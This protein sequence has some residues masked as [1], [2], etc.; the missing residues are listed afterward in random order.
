MKEKIVCDGFTG[1]DILIAYLCVHSFYVLETETLFDLREVITDAC[2]YGT[3]TF[4]N[5]N[6]EFLSNN[7]VTF[8]L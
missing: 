3:H 2:S 7:S 8:W 4:C 5:S 6:V 1:I